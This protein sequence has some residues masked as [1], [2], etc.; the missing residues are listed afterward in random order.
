[1]CTKD[2]LAWYCKD[3]SKLVRDEWRQSEGGIAYLKKIKLGTYG[4]SE[5]QFEQLLKDQD[6]RCAI[7]QVVFSSKDAP[8]IDHDHSCCPPRGHNAKYSSAYQG[9]P[10][11]TCGRCVRGLLC[12][13]C[14]IGLGMFDDNSERLISAINYLETWNPRSYL[15]KE[16][17]LDLIHVNY[18]L[19]M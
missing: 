2:N 6:G 1:M 5:E 3:C 7:C 11:T 9:R 15:V 13:K 17:S 12:K 19:N 18:V 4:L 10:M 14:N 16:E 8:A